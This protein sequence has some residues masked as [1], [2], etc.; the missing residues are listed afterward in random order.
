M[1][2]YTYI[3]VVVVIVIYSEFVYLNTYFKASR[4]IYNLIAACLR[5]VQTRELIIHWKMNNTG[6][7]GGGSG[8]GV[9]NINVGFSVRYQKHSP[10]ISLC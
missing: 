4:H 8:G 2:V 3:V 6:V 1:Y 10:L 5:R 9:L 7:T